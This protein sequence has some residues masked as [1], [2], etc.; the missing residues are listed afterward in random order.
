M[1]RR[2][3]L[4]DRD[5]TLIEEKNYLAD[6]AQVVL[7][8]GVVE[9]LRQLRAMGLGLLVVTNQSGVGRGYFTEAVVDAIH[10][11]MRDLL[12]ASGVD[13]DAFYHCPHVPEAACTCR[14]PLTGMV[15]KAAREL[16]FRADACF[17]VGDKPCDVELGR[18]L[19]ATTFLV[20]TGYGA[21]VYA[22]GYREADHVARDLSEVAAIVH[23]I[24][25]PGEPMDPH[26]VIRSHLEASASLKL[27]LAA[28]AVPAIQAVAL[29][30][31]EAFRKGGKLLLCG[32]GG[33]AADCQHMATE[34]TSRLT[35][36]FERPGI[37]AI[38]L[39]TDTSFLT[40]F[41]ND[42]G[43]DGVFARQVEALGRAGDV[44]LG[45]STSGGSRN[46]L[47]AMAQARRQGMTS[48]ALVGEGG[49]MVEQA[50]LVIQVPSRITQ[51]IQEAHLAIEHI[52]CHLV[53]RGLYAAEGERP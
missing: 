8:P 48:V 5:G 9:G 29:H 27:R 49:P 35:K 41:P 11:R 13:V 18:N 3:V 26:A 16:D 39:T 22:S 28:D 2:Y 45:I 23:R 6:P 44:L 25:H 34:F 21:Q 40:A 32:N 52:L 42:C 36:D 50:D 15:E 53:E 10:G 31:V 17:V 20:R 33:S 14:K 47:L 37:P 43:W 12:R 7:L 24:L 4:L 1:S 46:V 38:A 19:G 30:L 51:H